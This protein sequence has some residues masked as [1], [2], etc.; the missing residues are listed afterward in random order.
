MI[1]YADWV[2]LM[3]YDLHGVWDS[4]D[5]IGS[6]VQGHTNLTEIKL[7]VQLFWRVKVP[8]AMIV[9]GFGFYGRSFTLSSSSCST[10][11]CPFSGA[12][13]PGPCTATAGILGYY[14]ILDILKSDS[15]IKPTHDIADAVNYFKYNQNQWVSYDDAIT[16]GQKVQWAN[17]VGLGG[18]MIWASDLGKAF[19]ACFHTEM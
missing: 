12:S 10:P 13:N 15:S 4:T 19:R 5:P 18:G 9:M 14:E 2:N 3:S 11:G 7:A 16:F 6:I 8:P 17:S 1:K